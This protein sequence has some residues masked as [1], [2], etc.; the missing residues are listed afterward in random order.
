MMCIHVHVTYK[1]LVVYLGQTC[2]AIVTVL[3][4]T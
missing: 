2:I 3:M 4:H 1:T